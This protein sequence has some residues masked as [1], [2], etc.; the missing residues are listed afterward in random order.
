M[1]SPGRKDKKLSVRG[2]RQSRYKTYPLDDVQC[3]P[4]FC[5]ILAMSTWGVNE[6][7]K[8]LSHDIREKREGQL[9]IR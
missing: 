9:Q 4:A 5:Y 8:E 6:S 2:N 1:I 7:A 3:L